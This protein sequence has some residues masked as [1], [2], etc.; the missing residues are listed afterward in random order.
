MTGRGSWNVAE[1]STG[2]S[3]IATIAFAAA[4][5]HAELPALRSKRANGWAET[6]YA[7]LGA[8]VGALAGGLIAIGVRPADRVAILAATSA[9][10][11]CADLAAAAAGAIVVPIYPTSP[12][13]DCAYILRHSQTRVVFCDTPQTAMRILPLADEVGLE[14]V[15]VFDDAPD[16][17]LS[18]DDLLLAGADVAHDEVRARAAAIDPDDL[19]TLMYTSGTTGRPKGCKLTHA[20]L[21]ANLDMI[22]AVVP[23]GRRPELFA[24]LP[25][26]HA[27]TRMLQLYAIDVGGTLAYWN[28]SRET[29]LADLAEARPT[30]LASI[31]RLYEK[32]YAAIEA[33]VAAAGPFKRRTFAFAVA[34]G[35]AAAERERRGRRLGPALRIRRAAADRLVLSKVRQVFG[36]ELEIASTGAAPTEPELVEFFH[37][38]GV[39]VMEGYG[40]TESTAVTT[41]NH[42]GAVKIGTTGRPLPGTEL[43]LADDGEILIRGAHVFRGYYRDPEATSEVLVDGWLHSGDLGEVD[44]DGYL[45]IVGRKKEIIITSSGKNIAPAKIED[46]LRRSRWISHAVVCGDR[47]PYLVALLTLDP[48]ETAALAEHVGVAADD[49]E[50]AAHPAVVA[51]LHAAVRAA[52]E[53]LAP[54]E[55]VKRFAI[56]DRDLSPDHGELTAT[57]KVKRRVV[58][59][60]YADEIVALYDGRVT[61]I[62]APATVRPAES[63]RSLNRI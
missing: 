27:L 4:A 26:A 1:R 35:R 28:G 59:H 45:R 63:E 33:G 44:A 24:F 13:D 47:R 40:L 61:S 53:R 12:A 49:V 48:D 56:L 58:E 55:Q 52:N 38:C 21:R 14:R 31:P 3:T 10:W 34:A 36:G 32:L 51:E 18:L 2:A 6:S 20:N 9:E 57:L 46:A 60:R 23:E 50:L 17:T 7:Q 30:Q 29:L 11:T 5:A 16:G 41:I 25:L 42:P 19:C 62:E 37:A 22:E 8:R 43:K 54:I 15:V 39:P